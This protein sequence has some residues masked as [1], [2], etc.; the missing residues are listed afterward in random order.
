MA[1][2]E[3]DCEL[4]YITEDLQLV[5]DMWADWYIRLC[6]KVMRLEPARRFQSRFRLVGDG[7]KLQLVVS[8]KNQ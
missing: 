8:R 2:V 1:R 6:D 7:P 5:K 3:R 4:Y